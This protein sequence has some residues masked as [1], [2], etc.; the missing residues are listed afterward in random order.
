MELL[1]KYESMAD[2]DYGGFD[3]DFV[4]EHYYSA[5]VDEND[6]VLASSRVHGH[7]GPILTIYYDGRA[8]P[9]WKY[10]K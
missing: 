2:D 5:F 10:S 4:M 3:L 6:K 7:Y 1:T 8:S 9:V